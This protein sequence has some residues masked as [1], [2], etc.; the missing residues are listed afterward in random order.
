MSGGRPLLRGP[1]LIDPP[2]GGEVFLLLSGGG[3]PGLET[4][5]G[6][7]LFTN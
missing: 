7:R 4:G 5:G 1:D 6:T 2:G 3:G